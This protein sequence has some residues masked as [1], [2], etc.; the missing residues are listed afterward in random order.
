M[1][2]NFYMPAPLCTS[3]TKVQKKIW[4]AIIK[5]EETDF[6]LVSQER[7]FALNGPI[8]GWNWTKPNTRN[9]VKHL[10]ALIQRLLIIDY[11]LD[12]PQADSLNLEVLQWREGSMSNVSVYW[13]FHSRN[14]PCISVVYVE[15]LSDSCHFEC[16]MF[17]KQH[18]KVFLFLE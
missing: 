15:V 11:V 10:W 13:G 18:R 12:Y 4:T 8:K 7:S 6:N 3:N 17:L 1:W 5:I 14:L 9:C 2:W 16:T